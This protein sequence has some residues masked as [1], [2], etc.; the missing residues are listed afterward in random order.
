[1]FKQ[2]DRQLSWTWIQ[3]GVF[4]LL[5][6]KLLMAHVMF[7]AWEC[8]VLLGHTTRHQSASLTNISLSHVTMPIT[9]YKMI[10]QAE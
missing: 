4:K 6:N 3:G 9:S 7:C 5:T 10:I 2:P 1:M 8:C